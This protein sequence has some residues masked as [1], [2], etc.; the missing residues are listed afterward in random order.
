LA[1]LGTVTADTATAKATDETQTERILRNFS[2]HQNKLKL[3]KHYPVITCRS[4]NNYAI[5]TLFPVVLKEN[6]TLCVEFDADFQFINLLPI[7]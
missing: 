3:E 1:V 4:N 6:N 7:D 2:P 5:A